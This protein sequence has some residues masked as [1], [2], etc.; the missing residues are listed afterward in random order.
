MTSELTAIHFFGAIV[1]VLGLYLGFFHNDW[2][3][4]GIAII[5]GSMS[6][7]Y[8]VISFI[9]ALIEHFEHSNSKEDVKHG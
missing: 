7:F 1:F 6:A 5:I 3:A 4:G 9:G 8:M 2:I